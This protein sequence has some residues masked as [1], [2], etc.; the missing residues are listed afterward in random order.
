[1]LCKIQ[2]MEEQWVQ[3]V[4]APKQTFIMP[5]QNIPITIQRNSLMIWE[6]RLEDFLLRVR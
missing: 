6:L 2:K 4:L 1:M 5:V 3:L